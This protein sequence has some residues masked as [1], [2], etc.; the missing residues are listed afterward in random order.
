MIAKNSTTR[1]ADPK[2]APTAPS[3]SLIF[4]ATSDSAVMQHRSSRKA[5]KRLAGPASVSEKVTPSGVR[6]GSVWRVALA[7]FLAR[8]RE[9]QDQQ[10]Q[11]RQAEPD[12]Q[13]VGDHRLMVLRK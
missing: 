6:M 3:A 1:S 11:L 8:L 2:S 5:R 4:L 10:R 9:E 7:M 12:F 13:T